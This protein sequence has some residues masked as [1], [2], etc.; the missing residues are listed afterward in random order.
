MVGI[1]LKTY[2]S[3]A[4]VSLKW[5]GKQKATLW[6]GLR[7]SLVDHPPCD[8]VSCPIVEIAMVAQSPWS[9]DLRTASNRSFQPQ[10]LRGDIVLIHQPTKDSRRSRCGFTLVELLVVI[11]I[12]GTLIGL[13]L[14]AVQSAREA[15]RRMACQNNLKQ[16]SLACL[17]Y[18]DGA[19]KFP[20]GRKYDIW[21]A[22]TWTELVLPYVEQQ[23]VQ[24][25]YWTL[26]RKGY[27]IAPGLPS[28]LG[29]GG[30]DSRMRAARHTNIP[31]FYCPSD[32]TPSENETQ[33]LTAGFLRGN[34]SGCV[35]SGD[36]YGTTVDASQGPWG[37]GCFGVS[38]DQSFDLGTVNQCTVSR[39]VDGT[40]KTI[41]LSETIAANVPI[42][43]WGGPMGEIIYGN[44][45]G[46]LFSA[47]YQPNSDVADFIYGLCP[48][49]AGDQSY[50]GPCVDTPNIHWSPS[51]LGAY[52]SA[53]SRHI[54]GV[55]AAMADGSVRFFEDQIQRD[56][57]RALGTIA[58]GDVGSP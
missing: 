9:T 47:A 12:I 11:A 52:A 5:R 6:T 46:A 34:Y 54:S 53:R 51:A 39:I 18:L 38:R 7:E 49:R 16:L 30:D 19:R 4:A 48:A 3:Y 13:L 56:I 15:A 17:N 44:M 50:R 21:D 2:R 36:M 20:Y 40:S 58:T 35:G 8:G 37:I 24:D 33:T 10:C 55:L 32:R 41:L 29:P 45:G 42:P 1:R 25:N 31:V 23:A 28:P 57:S 43:A 27:V 14:P 22:Y 26:F